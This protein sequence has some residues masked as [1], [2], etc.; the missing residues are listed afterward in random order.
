MDAGDC[1][2]ERLHHADDQSGQRRQDRDNRRLHHRSSRHPACSLLLAVLPPGASSHRIHDLRGNIEQ[3]F[4]RGLIGASVNA[5]RP[6][7]QCLHRLADRPD[8][9]GSC[10][11][12]VQAPLSASMRRR[13]RRIREKNTR[14]LEQL[15]D[16]SRRRVCRSEQWLEPTSGRQN[17]NARDANEQIF[18]CDNS[19][20]SIP[21]PARGGCTR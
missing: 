4:V 8:I 15:L 7:R 14:V 2:R 16:R 13:S 6:H 19:F 11:K 18:A 1:R 5:D 21:S 9:V 17:T 20:D 3:T 10:S 12:R